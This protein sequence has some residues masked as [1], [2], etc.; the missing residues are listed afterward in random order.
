MKTIK[1]FIERGKDGSFGVY[2]NEDLPVGFFGD[3]QTKQEAVD[4]YLN[5]YKEMIQEVDGKDKEIMES[6]EFEFVIDIRSYLEYYSQFFTLAGLAKLTK[7]SASQ[8]SHYLNGY[9]TPSPKTAKKIED[10][11]ISFAND[12]E[13]LRLTR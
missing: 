1:A 12:L 2:H 6:L 8:L 11:L 4:D 9:K 10:G 3:G 5:S 13:G 7:V